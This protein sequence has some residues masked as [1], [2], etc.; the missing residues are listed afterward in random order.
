MA[1]NNPTIKLT[2]GGKNTIDNSNKSDL[3]RSVRKH[4][5]MTPKKVDSP[6]SRQET[7]TS[8][9]AR[10][11]VDKD[12]EKLISGESGHNIDRSPIQLDSGNKD[13]EKLNSSES[14]HKVDMN[15]VQLHSG[16]IVLSI[17]EINHKIT[18]LWLY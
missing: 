7:R 4:Q 5:V 6:K 16:K 10:H 1:E 12:P 8:S 2:D 17:D 15:P 9:K 11:D 14:E 18:N 3:R 13:P